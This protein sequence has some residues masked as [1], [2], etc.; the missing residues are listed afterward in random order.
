MR[1]IKGKDKIEVILVRGYDSN[2]NTASCNR[3][4]MVEKM[5]GNV[6]SYFVIRPKPLHS[7]SKNIYINKIIKQVNTIFSIFKI[8][9][10]AKNRSVQYIVFLRSID[11]IIG[12]LA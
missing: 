12:L 6:F 2:K 3:N 7:N 4:E 10:Y 8:N 9:H 11:P 1:S 5:V